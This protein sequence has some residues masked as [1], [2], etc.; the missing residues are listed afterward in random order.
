MMEQHRSNNC[1]LVDNVPASIGR[2]T[3][4]LKVFLALSSGCGFV[5]KI[6]YIYDPY[7]FFLLKQEAGFTTFMRT[8]RERDHERVGKKKDEL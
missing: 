1:S 6:V 4:K 2:W 3:Q 5:Q 7:I 8:L